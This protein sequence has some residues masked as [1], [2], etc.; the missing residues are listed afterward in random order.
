MKKNSGKRYFS[1][2]SFKFENLASQ[3]FKNQVSDFLCEHVV[4]VPHFWSIYTLFSSAMGT[5]L[6]LHRFSE[7]FSFVENFLRHWGTK[8]SW[9]RS[10]VPGYNV[11]FLFFLFFYYFLL[12]LDVIQL[13]CCYATRGAITIAWIS[14]N[15]V[16]TKASLTREKK[17]LETNWAK[18]DKRNLPTPLNPLKTPTIH[19]SSEFYSSSSCYSYMD[20]LQRN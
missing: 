11:F 4:D 20:E 5:L 19:C 3:K 6:F 12:L 7:Y 17:P 1:L 16:E 15:Q 18:H 13:H 2:Y 9:K 14:L 8:F 10:I